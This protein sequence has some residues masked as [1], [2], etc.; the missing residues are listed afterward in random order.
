MIGLAD[1]QGIDHTEVKEK[2]AT[3]SMLASKNTI[4]NVTTPE[5]GHHWL[6]VLSGELCVRLKEA[7]EASP[8]L[9]PKTIVLGTRIG[10]NHRTRQLPFPYARELTPEF[11]TKQARKLWDEATVAIKPGE[12]RFNNVGGI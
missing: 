12:M 1:T 6:S 5:Q 11:I 9:W 2:L 3:K 10:W 8:G 4:P 7:R